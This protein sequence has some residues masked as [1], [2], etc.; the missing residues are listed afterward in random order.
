MPRRSDIPA[1]FN[2]AISLDPKGHRLVSTN[3]FVRELAKLNHIWTR[4]EANRW[5]EYYQTCFV[6]KS[7]DGKGNRVFLLGNMGYVR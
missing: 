4:Q 6:E 2:N 7:D 3:D 1:A 5:I